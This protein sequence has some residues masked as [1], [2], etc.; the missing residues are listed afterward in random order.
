MPAVLSSLTSNVAPFLLGAI[1]DRRSP[2]SSPISGV[3]L[4]DETGHVKKENGAHGSF[5]Q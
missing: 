4:T 5:L 2:V 3:C 1:H